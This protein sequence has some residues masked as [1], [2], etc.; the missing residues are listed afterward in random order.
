MTENK[1]LNKELGL[2]VDFPFEIT[3]EIKWKPGDPVTNIGERWMEHDFEEALR[4]N[5]PKGYSL[6]SLDPE[7]FFGEFYRKEREAKFLDD[8][9]K[10]NAAAKIREEYP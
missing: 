1:S 3:E 9:L 7:A 8:V 5:D 2:P 4:E 10:L 6:Y